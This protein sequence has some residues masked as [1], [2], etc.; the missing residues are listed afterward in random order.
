MHKS[1]IVVALLFVS[2][3]GAQWAKADSCNGVSA[4]KNL[5]QNCA[6]GTGDFTDWSGSAT[7]V[8]NP[9]DYVTPLDSTAADPNPYVGSY[10]ADLG[11]IDSTATLSETFATTAGHGYE[12]EFAL[13]ND[14]GAGDGYDNSFV[15]D[16]GSDQLLSLT[17][18]A[19]SS[20]W[21]LYTY[22]VDATGS[23][24]TLS[25]TDDNDAGDWDL[26]SVSVAATPEPGSFLLFG[27]GLLALAGVARR[28]LSNR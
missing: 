9:Y 3:L 12:V 10:E 7:S 4:A 23:S 24:T 22:Y 21:T 5:I 1:S 28:R 26:D 8:T 25:F 19:E 27:T 20:G 14:T 11:D 2:L 17:N 13:Q 18:V 6:F 16:F 15:A